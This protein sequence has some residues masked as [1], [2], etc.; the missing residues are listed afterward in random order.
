MPLCFALKER[1]LLPAA[2]RCCSKRP[3]PP[4]AARSL[5]PAL[6]YSLNASLHL[7]LPTSSAAVEAL[8]DMSK[9]ALEQVPLQ[10]YFK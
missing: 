9:G 6:P 3:F 5:V 4:A 10:D 2:L 1:L 7:P 8:R